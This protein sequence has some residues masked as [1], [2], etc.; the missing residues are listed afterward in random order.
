MA[1][2]NNLVDF[3]VSSASAKSL[4]GPWQLENGYYIAYNNIGYQ[5]TMLHAYRMDALR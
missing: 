5:L 2:S 1:I 3:V 4:L